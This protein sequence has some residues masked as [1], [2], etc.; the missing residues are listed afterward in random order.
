MVI[1]GLTKQV[2]QYFSSTRFQEL[3]EADKKL[4]STSSSHVSKQFDLK[5]L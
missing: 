4:Q 3:L 2:A 5:L 1:F